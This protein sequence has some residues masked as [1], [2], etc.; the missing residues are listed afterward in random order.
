MLCFSHQNGDSNSDLGLKRRFSFSFLSWAKLIDLQSNSHNASRLFGLTQLCSYIFCNMS[1]VDTRIT[2]YTHKIF[3]IIA[4]THF[5]FKSAIPLPIPRY[6]T[7]TQI[8]FKS[9]SN[10]D[11]QNTTDTFTIID[12]EVS[13]RFI[14]GHWS[15]ES[16]YSLTRLCVSTNIFAYGLVP[17]SILLKC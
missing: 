6:H 4:E 7:Y 11:Q 5:E 2:T 8:S 17:V 3:F 14:D 10:H 16:Q 1:L 12:A 13:K 9:G 15:S